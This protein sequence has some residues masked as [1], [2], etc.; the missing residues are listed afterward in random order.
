MLREK[1]EDMGEMTGWKLKIV[2]RTGRKLDE[3]LHKSNHWA[4]KDC[5]RKGCM[6]FITKAK[7]GE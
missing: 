4:G 3:N 5:E 7:S 2:E 6:L 1:E